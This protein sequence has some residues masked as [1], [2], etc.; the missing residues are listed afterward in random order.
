[1]LL[2]MQ[3]SIKIQNI[4]THVTAR[5]MKQQKYAKLFRLCAKR[6]SSPKMYAIAQHNGFN[7]KYQA[8]RLLSWNNISTFNS[9]HVK[10]ICVYTHAPQDL[11]RKIW[12]MAQRTKQ[13][14]CYTI[15]TEPKLTQNM[16]SVKGAE[17]K[18]SASSLRNQPEQLRRKKAWFGCVKMRCTKWQ[19]ISFTH[20]QICSK[21]RQA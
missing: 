3:T 11:Y 8:N 12:K 1:M 5:L 15:H 14:S 4:F 21:K 16:G 9:L 17:K 20:L 13:H 10:V 7:I 6:I 18:E 2:N 19:K